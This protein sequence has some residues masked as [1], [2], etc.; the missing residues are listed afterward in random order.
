MEMLENCIKKV[1]LNIDKFM[2]ECS[3]LLENEKS[4]IEIIKNIDSPYFTEE[5]LK[6][7]NDD[8][9]DNENI[10][11]VAIKIVLYM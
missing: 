4:I 5:I 11:L 2:E 3:H 8:L 7:L 9:K 10:I 6:N 1:G